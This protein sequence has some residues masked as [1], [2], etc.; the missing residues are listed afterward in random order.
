MT[1]EVL[2]FLS[3]KYFKNYKFL[4]YICGQL[5]QCN[6]MISQSNISEIV[7]KISTGYKPAKIFLFGSYATGT[8]HPDSDLDFIIIKNTNTPKIKRGREV[9]KILHGALVPIDLKIYTPNEFEEESLNEF[10]FLHNALKTSKVVYE[11]S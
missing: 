8:P 5:W 1:S 6:F 2:I 7:D 10:S 11:Q 9:R 3:K 4:Y